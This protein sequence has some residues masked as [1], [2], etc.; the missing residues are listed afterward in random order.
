MHTFSD[1]LSIHEFLLSDIKR[2]IRHYYLYKLEN[3]PSN[4]GI[5]NNPLPKVTL[6]ETPETCITCFFL[7]AFRVAFGTEFKPLE[8][9]KVGPLRAAGI[10]SPHTVDFGCERTPKIYMDWNARIEDLVC[11]AHE[12][13]N[14]LQMS[15]TSTQPPVARETSAFL[16]ELFLIKY[17]QEVRPDLATLAIACWHKENDV[18]LGE[19][20]MDLAESLEKPDTPY[21]YRMNYPLARLLAINLVEASEPAPIAELFEGVQKPIL[22]LKTLL[23]KLPQLTP[24]PE[25]KT[26]VG[27]QLLGSMFVLD[28]ETVQD[29]TSLT[30]A[31]YFRGAVSH[32]NDQSI[33]YV[34][35]KEHRPMG[36][37]TSVPR[38]QGA[39]QVQRIVALADDHGFVENQVNRYFRSNPS[40]VGE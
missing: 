18:Y 3:A 32:L 15:M 37:G 26:K 5:A 25:A 24:D 21:Q 34:F 39:R 12:M 10:T 11:L 2:V 28:Q 36:Y 20:L 23:Q 17:L 4:W 29:Q 30:I 35:D 13:G 22:S 27:Y 33:H 31:D 19:D 9:I 1:W 16:A 8:K 7:P 38:D 6:P 40:A 14:A